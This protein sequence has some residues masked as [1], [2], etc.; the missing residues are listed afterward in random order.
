MLRGEFVRQAIHGAVFKEIPVDNFTELIQSVKKVGSQLDQVLHRCGEN[1]KYSE[2][3][4]AALKSN[5]ET[6]QMLWD[7]FAQGER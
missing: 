4:D 6:E 5:Y 7:T 2:E 3:L 1:K